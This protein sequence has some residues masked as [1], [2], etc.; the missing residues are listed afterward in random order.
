LKIPSSSQA[1]SNSKNSQVAL[2][3]KL[4]T[5]LG[6]TIKERSSNLAT[7]FALTAIIIPTASSLMYSIENI[8]NPEEFSDI[9]STF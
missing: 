3:L 4:L 1:S 7:S 6:N 5:L 9:V 2:A 8:V